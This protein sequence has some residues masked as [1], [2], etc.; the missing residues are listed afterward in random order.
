[1][2]VINLN[3]YEAYLLDN[4]EGNLSEEL[5]AELKAFAA[6]HPE[7]E[8]DLLDS[9]L[10]VFSD[11]TI[12][13]TFKKELLKTGDQIPNEDLLNYLEGILPEEEKILMEARLASDKALAKD[14]EIYK[15]TIL[16]VDADEILNN[17]KELFKSEDELILNSKVIAY[18]E[19]DLNSTEKTDFETRLLKEKSLRDE[20]TLVKHT[21]LEADY[22]VIYPGKNNLKKEGRVV[23]L[24]SLK[25]IT[26]VAAAILLVLGIAFLLKIYSSKEGVIKTEIA[27]N[28]NN[29]AGKGSVNNEKNPAI[30]QKE[31]ITAIENK[32]VANQTP[33]KINKS[34]KRVV[35][36]TLAK[37]QQ[38]ENIVKEENK[39]PLLIDEI[40]KDTNAL[41]NN[42]ANINFK[43]ENIS[44]T[45]PKVKYTNI[46]ALALATDKEENQTTP[47]KPGFWKR[48][49]KVAQKVNGLGLKA[50]K[51][52]E[53]EN[54][55]YSLSFNSFSVEKK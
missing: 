34:V 4:F 14:F 6:S 47:S 29:P 28:N 17:K 8:I 38:P 54:E 16:P 51:G 12:N 53:K 49:V 21:K 35:I 19:N 10:P 13:F 27:K 32:I 25:I 41:V 9:E 36:D 22:S 45:E 5:T 33:R 20:L 7:L 43:K 15:K 1:M 44:A 52:D 30:V 31:I 11:E 39:T 48:A 18:Y 3:N 55:N 2:G 42:P 23:A 40:K 37:Q 24:F 46:N 26:R 50:V